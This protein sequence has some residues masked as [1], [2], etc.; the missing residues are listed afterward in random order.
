MITPQNKLICLEQFQTDWSLPKHTKKADE[1]SEDSGPNYKMT[2]SLT[3]RNTDDRF[4]VGVGG[5]PPAKV[6]WLARFFHWLLALFGTERRREEKLL[7]IEEFFVSVKN[8]AKEIEVLHG[9]AEGFEQALKRAKQGG[10][11]AYIEQLSAGLNAYRMESQLLAMELPRY[12]EEDD[13]V[14]FYKQS[15]KGLRLDW[16]QNFT[17]VIPEALLTKKVRADELGLFDNYVVLHYDPQA[18]SYAE[19]EKEKEAKKKAKDPILFGLMAG[20]RR[21]YIVGDWIDEYCDLTV[22]Q[23]ADALGKD[24]VKE[25]G[26]DFA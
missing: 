12:L 2:S 4:S 19:T 23:I 16:V 13:L 17:R 1:N 11:Q 7:P 14:R 20:R 24:V 5:A 18:K 15:K 25:I 8:S 26:K 21:L 3:I 10:Q 6:S 22:D 9:R